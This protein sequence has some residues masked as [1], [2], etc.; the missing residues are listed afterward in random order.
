MGS[1]PRDQGGRSERVRP[2]VRRSWCLGRKGRR[3]CGAQGFRDAQIRVRDFHPLCSTHEDRDGHPPRSPPSPPQGI[4]VAWPSSP[5][6]S[7]S[8]NPEKPPSFLP[9]IPGKPQRNGDWAMSFGRWAKAQ[10]TFLPPTAAPRP[11]APRPAAHCPALAPRA[12]E[13]RPPPALR[14][15]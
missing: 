13:L 11:A 15:P 10:A 6:Q 5:R 8:L 14:P 2:C 9:R 7:R 12:R 4:R 3:R 1:A